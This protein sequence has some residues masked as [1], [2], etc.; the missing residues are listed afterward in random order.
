MGVRIDES[1]VSSNFDFELITGWRGLSDSAYEAKEREMSDVRERIHDLIDRFETAG[2]PVT[3]NTVGHLALE[4]CD[5]HEFD[6][7]RDPETDRSDAGLWYAPDLVTR[8]LDADAD[9]EIG[10]HSFSHPQFDTISRERANFELRRSNEIASTLGVDMRSFVYPQNRVGYA[11]LLADHGFDVVRRH[12][13]SSRFEQA[14]R[15]ARIVTGFDDP[16]PTQP[17]VTTDG[18]VEIRPSLSLEAYDRPKEEIFTRSPFHRGFKRY[19]TRGLER[20]VDEGGVFHVH[21]HPEAFRVDMPARRIEHLIEEIQRLESDGLEVVTMS[22]VAAL[23][24]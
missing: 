7:E 24:A 6:I 5:G 21:G 2:V 15:A 19:L 13:P 14:E 22:E 3:W 9:F 10:S 17:R 4:A 20:T 23:C 12:V 16:S 1:Y 8:L 11:E 18:V